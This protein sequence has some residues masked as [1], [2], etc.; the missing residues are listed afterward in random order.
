MDILI[1]YSFL[2]IY[3]YKKK[4]IFEY[5][6]IL[7]GLIICFILHV[8]LFNIII[9]LIVIS[10]YMI[11]FYSHMKLFKIINQDKLGK[12]ISFIK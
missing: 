9:D 10:K 1:L 4:N 5:L 7:H 8:L 12:Q 11:I 6:F 3:L 2:Y